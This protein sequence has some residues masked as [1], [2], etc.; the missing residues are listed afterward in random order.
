MPDPDLNDPSLSESPND[1][2]EALV[3]DTLERMENEGSAAIESAVREHPEYAHEIRSRLKAL[4]AMGLVVDPLDG[5]FEIPKQIGPFVLGASLGEG[6][7]GLVFEAEDPVL[8]RKVAIKLIRPQY[9]T[10]DSLR[11]RFAREG[12]AIARLQHP[13]VARV[14]Q[15]GEEK[16]L[17]FLVMERVFGCTL[18]DVLQTLRLERKRDPHKRL[19]GRDW[20][21]IV[22]QRGGIP[23]DEAGVGFFTGSWAQV[24]AKIAREA[25]EGLAHAHAAGVLHRDVKASN[26]MITP[27][28]RVLLI[29]FGL[30]QLDTAVT[31]TASGSHLGSLPYTAPERIAP[32]SEPTALADVYSL[33]VVMYEM[34]SLQLPFQAGSEAQLIQR[35]AQGRA[36]AIDR[37]IDGLGSAHVEVVRRAMRRDPARRPPSASA[38]ANDL[39]RV[40]AGKAPIA[41]GDG[42]LAMLGSRWRAQ[43]WMTSAG[44]AALLLAWLLPTAV[45]SVRA[46][47][48]EKVAES[49]RASL[50]RLQLALDTTAHLKTVLPDSPAIEGTAL[51][52]LRSYVL[53]ELAGIEARVQAERPTDGAFAWA[54]SVEASSGFQSGSHPALIERARA[55]VARGSAGEPSPEWGPQATQIVQELQAIQTHTASSLDVDSV[56]I[57]LMQS[58]A[59]HARQAGYASLAKRWHS[60]ASALCEDLQRSLP[61]SIWLQERAEALR[62]LGEELD[63]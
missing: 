57:E 11:Q 53:H 25:A 47:A 5:S 48:A 42:L 7:M 2:I 36:P 1:P 28:G 39:T 32:G 63:S 54:G 33:G 17:P 37:S 3:F 24:V 59:T 13:A 22:G 14:F 15:V 34:L 6:G 46:D 10:R 44:I 58:L 51:G 43:P 31:L 56:L 29:D 12:Q 4:Q 38:L 16:G 55:W 19:V 30:A 60:Q 23:V 40:L 9:V 49:D 61:K 62:T 27:E 20:Q 52:T 45:L 35:I 18:A 26:I 41:H 21:R 8:R 50:Q